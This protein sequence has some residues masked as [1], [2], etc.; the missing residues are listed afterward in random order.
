MFWDLFSSVE[1]L[2]SFSYKQI[3]NILALETVARF[4]S[5]QIDRDNAEN[6]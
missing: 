4:H 2:R 3:K 5:L 6:E 1:A